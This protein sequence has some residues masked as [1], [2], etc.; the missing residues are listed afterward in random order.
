VLRLNA[1]R[2]DFPALASKLISEVTTADVAAW[3]DARLAVVW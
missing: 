2:K 1:I 3:R